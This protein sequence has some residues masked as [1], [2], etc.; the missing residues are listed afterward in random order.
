MKRYP[1]DARQATEMYQDEGIYV[2]DLWM[3]GAVDKVHPRN[4]GKDLAAVGD[5]DVDLGFTRQPKTP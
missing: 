2:F 1:E 4:N 3:N 5:E